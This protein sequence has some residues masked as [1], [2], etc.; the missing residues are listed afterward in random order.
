MTSMDLDAFESVEVGLDELAMN[1]PRK[2]F[3]WYWA[4]LAEDFRNLNQ[5]LV[6]AQ[7]SGQDPTEAIANYASSGHGSKNRLV[8][9]LADAAARRKKSD[10]AGES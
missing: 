9:Y 7:V 2:H 6:D 5:T 10:E 8:G 1:A 4:D 3:Q